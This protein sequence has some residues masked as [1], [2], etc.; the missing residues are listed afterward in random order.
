MSIKIRSFQGSFKGHFN[1]I[2]IDIGSMINM[3][4]SNG[5]SEFDEIAIKPRIEFSIGY[6][7][8]FLNIHCII[9]YKTK[10]SKTCDR[11]S[12][13]LNHQNP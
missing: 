8:F 5:L 10:N 9:C 2:F 7:R 4:Y 11:T 3:A 1:I 12:F 13:K 6:K